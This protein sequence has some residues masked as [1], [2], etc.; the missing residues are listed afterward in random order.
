[1][2]GKIQKICKIYSIRRAGLILF[3]RKTALIS[4]KPQGFQDYALKSK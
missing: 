2:Q 4:T 3:L 1:M